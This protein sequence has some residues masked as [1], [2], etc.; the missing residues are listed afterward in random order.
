MAELKIYSEIDSDEYCY[1]WYDEEPYY[2]SLNSIEKF[3]GNIP[4]E[5][6]TIDMLL[7]SRGGNV[8]EGFAIHDSLQFNSVKKGLTLNATVTGTCASIATVILL[9]APKANRK[10]YP[11]ATIMIHNPFVYTWDG[12][13]ANSVAKLKEMLDEAKMELLNFYCKKLGEDKRVEIEAMMD[14]ETFLNAEEALRLGFI[15]EILPQ[16]NNKKIDKMAKKTNETHTKNKAKEALNALK[17]YF[18]GDLKALDVTTDAGETITVEGDEIVEGAVV[19][20]GQADG[21]YTLDDGQVI[22]IEAGVI[23]KITPTAEEEPAEEAVPTTEEVAKLKS[24]LAAALAKLEANA[25]ETASLRLKAKTA[26]DE[27]VLK[28]VVAA[29]GIDGLKALVSDYQ[30]QGKQGTDT[31]SFG[32]K[33]QR[34]KQKNNINE[35]KKL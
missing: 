14:K 24:D 12:L 20:S 27:I 16:L 21:D 5:D 1:Y 11:N 10:I 19:T 13:D 17:A 6:K 35:F 32:L 15:N 23:T 33:A 26:D 28:A 7:H 18:S 34:E 2:V 25:K 3:I 8:R 29:G 30:P 22:T 31:P 4:Q 9:A